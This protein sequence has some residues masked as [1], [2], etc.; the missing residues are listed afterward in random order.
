MNTTILLT[1]CI[2]PLGMLFTELQDVELRKKHYIE[3]ILFYLQNTSFNIVFC[4][5]SG[6]DISLEVKELITSKEFSRLEFIS[7]SGNN[8]EKHL[9]KGYGEFEIIKKAVLSST[10]INQSKY[11]LKITGRYIADDIES[12]VKISNVVTNWKPNRIYVD[13]SD[14]YKSAD[15]RCFYA[16]K[17]FLKYFVSQENSV[18]DNNKFYFEHLFYQ[19]L[20][21]SSRYENSRFYITTSFV[22][23]GDLISGISGTL[24]S[25]FFSR[26]YSS[27]EKL[28]LLKNYCK[29]EIQRET[30]LCGL[31]W[32]K[33]IFYILRIL[34]FYKS[35]SRK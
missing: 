13:Y 17:E 12:V 28:R 11:V 6:E 15:A 35:Q 3:A 4:N 2:N 20:F 5:N 21:D 31:I 25:S 1:A 24:G 7:Y 33:T 27:T 9:G 26:K 34:N 23:M 14:K 16:C 18:N 29:T 22:Y 30:N 32:K 10:F 19:V 8:Y